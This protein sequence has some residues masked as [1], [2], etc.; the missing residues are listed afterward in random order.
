MLPAS[1]ASLLHNFS[2]SFRILQDVIQKNSAVECR[3]F[4]R[5][6]WVG[7]AE[8]K[9][10]H[11][12]KSE[13]DRP[14]RICLDFELRQSSSKPPDELLNGKHDKERNCNIEFITKLLPDRYGTVTLLIRANFGID[15]FCILKKMAKTVHI[16]FDDD[17]GKILM[18]GLNEQLS[19][20]VNCDGPS[21]VIILVNVFYT[22][23]L[24]FRKLIIL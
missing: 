1:V 15:I 3:S 7:H 22:E 8:T 2:V 5:N 23:K 20:F 14:L 18:A 24:S 4:I 11:V 16:I 12:E 21:V 6:V 17:A 19:V 9:Y 13:D 10:V